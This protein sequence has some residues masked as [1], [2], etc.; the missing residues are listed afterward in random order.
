MK[1]VLVYCDQYSEMENILD[2]L[3]ISGFNS[4]PCLSEDD[5]LKCITLTHFDILLL[6]RKIKNHSK[7]VVKENLKT[8]HPIIP[9]LECY[10][11]YEN[12][13]EDIIGSLNL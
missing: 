2:V 3:D 1:T 7:A 11:P 8:L 9:I 13:A 5:V 10:S 6:D 12:L 4:I